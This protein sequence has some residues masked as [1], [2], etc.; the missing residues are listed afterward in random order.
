[1][2]DVSVRRHF[3]CTVVP[4]TK[5]SLSS[6]DVGMSQTQTTS[7]NPKKMLQLS[8]DLFSSSVLSF[9]IY[10]ALANVGIDIFEF[11]CH[12]SELEVSMCL[13]FDASISN[14]VVRF[15]CVS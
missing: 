6:C 9:T 4:S 11:T 3:E 5:N 7:L 10:V 14:L 8:P 15:L 12:N 1:M 13:V 2:S